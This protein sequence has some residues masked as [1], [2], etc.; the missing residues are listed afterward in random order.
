M[1]DRR[2]KKI[3]QITVLVSLMMVLMGARLHAFTVVQIKVIRACDCG[4]S[5]GIATDFNGYVKANFAKL[6]RDEDIYEA[7][8]P[9][10]YGQG[11]LSYFTA[12]PGATHIVFSLPGYNLLAEIYE[13]GQSGTVVFT[14]PLIPVPPNQQH[15]HI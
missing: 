15:I 4:Y 8:V 2:M 14:L 1:E 13:V 11:T 5:T 9:I 12:P 7:N 10:T 6:A 3:L